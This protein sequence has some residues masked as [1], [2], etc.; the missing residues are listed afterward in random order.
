MKD[1]AHPHIFL[2]LML[3]LIGAFI[4]AICS[5][6]NRSLQQTPAPV[7]VIYHSTLGIILSGTYICVEAA[8]TGD[9]FRFADYTKR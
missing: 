6:L 9:S 7:I 2:G 1:D 3:T 4:L 8:I 5:V